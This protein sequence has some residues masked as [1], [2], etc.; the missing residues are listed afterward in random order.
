MKI[1]LEI[2]GNPSKNLTLRIRATRSESIDR[3]ELITWIARLIDFWGDFIQFAV[4]W[5][6][7]RPFNWT[8]PWRCFSNLGPPGPV[9]DTPWNDHDPNDLRMTFQEW[10]LEPPG[11]DL[12]PPGVDFGALLGVQDS[13][14]S[15]HTCDCPYM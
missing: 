2:R 10:I 8:R 15:V 9:L 7:A 4:R 14:W 3:E 5:Y 1:H 11:E 12:D 6:G 13:P